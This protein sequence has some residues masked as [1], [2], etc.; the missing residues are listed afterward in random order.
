MLQPVL[1]NDI[2][3]MRPLV[4]ADY[5]G[6]YAVASDPLIWAVHPARD[7]WKPEVFDALFAGSLASEGALVACVGEEIIGSSRYDLRDAEAGEVEI[8]WTFLARRF[9]GGAM[10]AAMK[11]LM[12]GHALQ[13]FERVIFLVGEENIRSRRAM[14]KIGGVLTTRTVVRDLGG[15]SFSHVVYEIDRAGF[16]AGPL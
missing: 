10:N 9:W 5:D 16:A 1:S 6:L 8:G 11:S 12:V 7:R 13:H 2:L 14:E 3:T 15:V 4:A